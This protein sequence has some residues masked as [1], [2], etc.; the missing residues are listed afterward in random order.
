VK[1]AKGRVECP[2][3]VRTLRRFLSG[4]SNG[5][6]KDQRYMLRLLLATEEFEEASKTAS[7][8]ASEEQR[9][10]NY[11]MA[12]SVLLT[13]HHALRE[14]NSRFPNELKRDLMLLHSYILVK[15]PS[16]FFS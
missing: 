5:K 2:T 14:N 16:P 9:A 7:F 15:V 6:T 13:T 1:E 10:G 4:E 3:L 11:K 8:I 12:H